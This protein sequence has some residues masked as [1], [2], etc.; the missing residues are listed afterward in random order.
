MKCFSGSFGC[1]RERTQ[2]P[3]EAQGHP[4]ASTFSAAWWRPSC[5]E[6]PVPSGRCCRL[7]VG[8]VWWEVTDCNL[9]P[10]LAWVRHL[11]S[12]NVPLFKTSCNFVSFQPH[13]SRT[14]FHHR[15]GQSVLNCSE[16]GGCD[17]SAGK[18]QRCFE[19]NSLWAKRCNL[20]SWEKQVDG[21]LSIYFVIF[22][23][24]HSVW[25]PL[26]PGYLILQLSK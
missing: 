24:P 11:D 3:E 14:S 1:S 26:L 9:S 23:V 15:R 21:E 18:L 2:C 4:A 25:Y 12:H 10:G 7:C 20:G 13:T 17:S 19:P 5:S 6:E 22:Y 8:G 16:N